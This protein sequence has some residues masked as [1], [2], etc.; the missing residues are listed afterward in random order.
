MAEIWELFQKGGIVMYPLLVCSFAAI[1]I[2]IERVLYYRAVATDTAKLRAI[3]QSLAQGNSED[4]LAMA[5]AEQGDAAQVISE[6]LC[7]GQ[8]KN[9]KAQAL[10][11]KVNIVMGTYDD[12]LSFLNIIVTLAPLLGLLGTIFGIVSAFSVFDKNG[13]GQPFAITAGIGEALIATAFGLLV[14]ILTLI[15]Y[16]ILKYCIVH[17]NKRLEYSCLLLLS[18]QK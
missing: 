6:Y 3:G 10:E 7:S 2:F 5:E 1:A 18:A 16:G 17:L 8:E 4:A 15:L 14:A 9:V 11:T 13:N 12:K